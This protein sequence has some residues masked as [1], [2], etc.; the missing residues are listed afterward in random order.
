MVNHDNQ[1]VIV[2]HYNQVV[3]V[4]HHNQGVKALPSVF[5][6]MCCWIYVASGLGH[7]SL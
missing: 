3:T 7:K 4:Y 2:D 6:W 5:L 1:I